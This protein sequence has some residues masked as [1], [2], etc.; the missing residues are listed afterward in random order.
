M[1]KNSLFFGLY[2]AVVVIILIAILCG[3]IDASHLSNLLIIALLPIF[4]LALYELYHGILGTEFFVSI[5]SF[6]GFL[7]GEINT[8]IT[9]L[10]IVLIAKFIE[11]LIDEKTEK[12]IHSLLKLIPHEVTIQLDSNHYDIVDIKEVV[13]KMIVVVKAGGSIPVDG[14][15]VYGFAFVNESSLTGESMPK[16][17]G[18]GDDVFAGSF[19]ENGT[20]KIEVEKAGEATLFAKMKKSIEDSQKSKARIALFASNI[21]TILVPVILV[22]ISLVWLFTRNSK[23]VVTL[24]VFGSPLELTVITPLAFLAGVIAAFRQGILIKGSSVLER[25]ASVDLFAFDKTGTLTEGH[26]EVV[27]IVS[28]DSEYTIADILKLAAIA[29]KNSEHL[30]AQAVLIK[31]KLE[32]IEVADADSFESIVGYGVKI[33]HQ[34][35]TYFFG[36]QK[37]ADFLGIN[38]L[39]NKVDDIGCKSPETHTFFYIFS[40]KKVIGRICIS[41]RIRDNAKSVLRSLEHYGIK[42]LCLLSGDHE[43]IVKTIAGQLRFQDYYGG[44]LPEQKAEVIRKLQSEKFLLAMVGDG[45]NDAPSLKQADVGIVFGAMGIEPAVEAGDI[46]LMSNDL[47]KVLFV[48]GLSKKIMSIIKQN[49]LF[50]FVLIHFGGMALAFL[51]MLSPIQAALFHSFSDFIILINSFRIIRFKDHIR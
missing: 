4:I 37:Y 45:I 25:L 42:Q 24:L 49:V 11:A 34:G 32:G 20:I 33:T 17:K 35:D 47:N 50:G 44:L 18:I 10:L 21:A 39:D 19:V 30:I 22:L 38:I 1:I 51:G 46:V 9:I 48:V 5:A 14:K 40:E 36:S 23:L 29:E 27:E 31:A 26:L 8:I 2:I 7:S 16:E 3:F 15:I 28:L 6:V 13:P 12:A 43:K 41:D